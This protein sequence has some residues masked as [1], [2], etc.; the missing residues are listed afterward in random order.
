VTAETRTGGRLARRAGAAALFA[1]AAILVLRFAGHGPIASVGDDSLSYLD[2][3]RLFAGAAG[4][5]LAPWI[6]F[7]T[8][9]PPLFPLALAAAGGATDTDTAHLVVALFAVA[10]T[11]MVWRY[12]TLRLRGPAAGL[13]LMAAF[14]LTPSAWISI[15]GIL[16]ES[17]YLCIVVAALDCHARFLE[18]RAASAAAWLGFGTLV[19]A[20]VLTRAAGI[21]LVAAFIVQAA[22]A[23]AR[24]TAPGRWRPVLALVPVAAAQAAWLVLRPEASGGAYGRLAGQL[25]AAWVQAPIAVAG[26]AA[27]SLFG[28]WMESFLAEASGSVPIQCVFAALGA[29][30]LAG[31]IR[32]ARANR[33]DGWYALASV[34]LAFTWVF[35]EDAARRLLY[36]VLPVLLLHA[37]EMAI[38]LARR[39]GSRGTALLVGAG[40]ALPALLC[41][42]AF[43]L[44]QQKSLDRAPVFPWAR[45]ALADMT[46]YY[47][48]VNLQRARAL[49]AKNAA[50]L[51]GLEAIGR[52]TEPGARVM[53]MRPDYVALL[54]GRDSVPFYYDGGPDALARRVVESRADYVVAARLYKTD[55]NGR[56]GDPF[57]ALAGIERYARAQ[58]V[59]PNPFLGG[60]EFALLKVDRAAAERAAAAAK[61]SP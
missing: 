16:S 52:T 50:V 17:M 55:L 27:H 13:A 18:G 46:D 10:A 39:G 37:A 4:P 28:G 32:A 15:R 35:S 49:G 57:A 34:A 44:V 47:R 24:G 45:Y 51:A 41:V 20:A 29:L 58:F 1:L 33:L 11:A 56:Q 6:P 12:G 3:A 14:L 38:A 23:H 40:L 21:A 9:F 61:P 22:I 53:W 31:S 30:A 36:P 59:V 60:E 19:A 2:L 7:E 54:G 26:L 5:H 25:L 8:R 48:V 42:P 43:A